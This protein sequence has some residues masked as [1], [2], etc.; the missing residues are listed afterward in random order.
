[1]LV[2][3][4]S[5][6][7]HS[8][9]WMGPLICGIL[10]EITGTMR[11][12]FFYILFVGG[13][14]FVLTLKTDFTEGAE[15]CRRKEIQVR[16]EAVRNKLGVSKIQIQMNA[17]K[18]L[19]VKS[20]VSTASSV[21]SKASAV[22]STVESTV[23][24]REK[25]RSKSILEVSIHE[26]K[27]ED[28]VEDTTDNLLHRASIL[29]PGERLKENMPARKNSAFSIR[30]RASGS[31]SMHH[32]LNTSERSAGRTSVRKASMLVISEFTGGTTSTGVK[33]MPEK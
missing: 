3:T 19:G 29:E 14:G 30:S 5:T 11:T 7:G 21:A 25:S 8:R 13:I 24:T 28:V 33:V 26:V 12:A 4:L 6:S 23:E 16:M 1:M 22:E 18:F 9:S 27:H 31:I 17:K 10:Y 32:P 20:G 15:A 2:L